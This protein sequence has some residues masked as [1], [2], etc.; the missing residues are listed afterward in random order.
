MWPP[1]ANKRGRK[2]KSKLSLG[3]P[4]TKI[5]G[6]DAKALR[7]RLADLQPPVVRFVLLID[8]LEELFA[9]EVPAEKREQFLETLAIAFARKSGRR[10]SPRCEAISSRASPSFRRS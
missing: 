7:A 8:Q 3:K 1:S 6:D 5:G 4:K 2:R 10:S 9:A